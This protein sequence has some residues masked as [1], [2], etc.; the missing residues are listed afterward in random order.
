SIAKGYLAK[1]RWDF[2]SRY[3]QGVETQ[4]NRPSRNEDNLQRGVDST[5]NVVSK[6]FPN[7]GPPLRKG[8]LQT[9]DRDMLE[10]A[11]QYV[12]TNCTEVAHPIEM[13]LS[14]LKSQNPRATPHTIQRLHNSRFQSWFKEQVESRSIDI[15]IADLEDFEQLAQ[16]PSEVV[17]FFKGYIVNGFRFHTKKLEQ[18][19][20]TQNSGVMVTASTQSFASAR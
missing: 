9:L 10:K 12:L 3:L 8:R 1:E 11:H 15:P 14:L 7:V 13:H 17:R 5:T 18:K 2:C 6:I 16:K 19:R 20:K 4:F